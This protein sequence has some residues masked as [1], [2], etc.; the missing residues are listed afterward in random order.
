MGGCGGAFMPLST[1]L[2]PLEK[3]EVPSIEC[4]VETRRPPADPADALI[5]LED[6]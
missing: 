2:A 4:F 3:A 5:L 6:R 1:G